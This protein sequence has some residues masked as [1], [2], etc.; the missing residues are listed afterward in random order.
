MKMDQSTPFLVYFEG[1]S[2]DQREM[3]EIA[4]ASEY[5][6]VG[7]IVTMTD[8]PAYRVSPR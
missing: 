5:I 7:L 6:S 8:T 4:I 1:I 2:M 3:L